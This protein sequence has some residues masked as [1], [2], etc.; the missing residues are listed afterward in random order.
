M[1]LANGTFTTFIQRTIFSVPNPV[2]LCS[3]Q[4]PRYLLPNLE[5]ELVDIESVDI[6][7]FTK[8]VNVA[9]S[10]HTQLQL[11]NSSNVASLLIKSMPS[12][13]RYKQVVT[14]PHPRFPT[15]WF[16]LFWNWVAGE[17]LE[18]FSQCLV[19]PVFDSQSGIQAVTQLSPAS[20]SV[21]IPV[22]TARFT[23]SLASAL[24]KLGVSYCEQSSYH[25]VQH[26]Q[27]HTYLNYFSANGVLDA[28]CNASHYTN[29]SLTSQ[30]AYE[31]RRCLCDWTYTSQRRTTLRELSI[32]TTL[33]NSG[34]RLYSVTQANLQVKSICS[35]VQV[36]PNYFPLSAENFPPHF[37]LFASS[38]YHQLRLLQRLCLVPSTSVDFLINSVFPLIRN[39]SIAKSPTKRLMK[40]VLENI[41]T[42]TSGAK[43]HQK[44][45]LN[46]VISELLFVPVSDGS[47]KSPKSLFNPSDPELQSLFK[48]KSV[49]PIEPFVSE[50]CITILKSCGL[51]TTVSPKEIIDIIQEICCTST[52]SMPQP[53]D[54]ERYTR[55]KAVIEYIGQW[56][57]QMM[58]ESVSI[59]IKSSGWGP[60]QLRR[61][62]FSKAL[63]H[64][65]QKNCWLPVQATHPHDYPICLGWKGTD[66]TC[67][68]IS[69]QSSVILRYD[70]ASLASACGSQVYFVDHSLPAEICEI[71]SSHD[72]PQMLVKHII[73]HLDIV[74]C[75]H[76]QIVERVR[77]VTQIIYRFLQEY[78]HYTEQY[79][80][81][82]S[83]EC[84]CMDH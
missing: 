10:N 75:N 37:I 8:L 65:S 56:D 61:E 66:C 77:T 22:G 67:H 19:V 9:N 16:K 55:A 52:S 76:R 82:L 81:L 17:N 42:I 32:F 3:S 50:K 18:L 74:I 54:V 35:K 79:K 12:E 84:M 53:V 11:L 58:S 4:C 13:W 25:Y 80:T 38:E 29:V 45:T 1:P 69:F 21:L 34:E 33:P 39:G 64:F 43:Y 26:C 78:L 5:G 73:A 7:L 63:L 40:E 41:H 68:F 30:E 71:F 47:I 62:K 36:K 49:F 15:E 27:F 6:E 44:Q 46:D 51:R 20:P 24:S 2:Y 57:S 23:E 31:L 60:T 14:L 70:Q 72:E 59:E 83:E 48:G 28:I